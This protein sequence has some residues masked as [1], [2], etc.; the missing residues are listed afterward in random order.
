MS[1]TE[2]RDIYNICKSEFILLITQTKNKK[3]FGWLVESFRGL[4]V[5][6]VLHDELGSHKLIYFNG[7]RPQTNTF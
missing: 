1:N 5:V 7:L 4:G 3:N 6:P 2:E